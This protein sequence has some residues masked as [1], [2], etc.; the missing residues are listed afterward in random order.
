MCA[1]KLVELTDSVKCR[2]SYSQTLCRSHV[3]WSLAAIGKD[4]SIARHT[5]VCHKSHLHKNSGF[6][7]PT[8]KW[9]IFFYQLKGGLR[10]WP[11]LW[12]WDETYCDSETYSQMS[13]KV[14]SYNKGRLEIDLQ[15]GS[16]LTPWCVSDKRNK[17]GNNSLLLTLSHLILKDI[18]TKTLPVYHVYG[19]CLQAGGL[20]AGVRTRCSNT[21]TMRGGTPQ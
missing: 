14:L 8:H 6:R 17:Y 5:Q 4:N 18:P 21:L 10:D 13:L 9:D 12:L 7:S 1:R 20:Q 16:T 19:V 11:D 15:V 3:L 2:H